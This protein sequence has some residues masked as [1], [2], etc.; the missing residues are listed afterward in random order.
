V[1]NDYSKS[2]ND[3]VFEYELANVNSYR[4]FMPSTEDVVYE[5]N[6]NADGEDERQDSE[7]DNE[8]AADDDEVQ[9][10]GN[11]QG[12]RASKTKGTKGR[13]ESNQSGYH[14][15]HLQ[16]LPQHADNE[17]SFFRLF[18]TDHILDTIVDNIN[19]YAHDDR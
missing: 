3:S 9:G 10:T 12:K 1:I 6:R 7:P 17:L 5:V 18:F 16:N 15:A 8:R 13:N 2:D 4:Q 19:I 14:E 11:G